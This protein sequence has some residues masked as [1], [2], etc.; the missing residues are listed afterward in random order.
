[1]IRVR[2]RVRFTARAT[3]RARIRFTARVR[4]GQGLSKGYG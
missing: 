3:V 4:L 2:D 1:M